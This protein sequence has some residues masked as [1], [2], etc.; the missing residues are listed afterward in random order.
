MAMRND[1][2]D[3]RPIRRLLQRLIQAPSA[4]ALVW[5]MVLLIGSFLAYSRW[6]KDHFNTIHARLEPDAVTLSEPHQ[7]VRT[8]LSSEVYDATRLRDLSPIDHNATA[9][10]ASAF[11]S[12][13]WVRHVQSVRKL[14]GGK[15]DVQLEYREPVAVFHV[16]S[17]KFD[18]ENGM[19]FSLDHEGYLLPNEKLTFDDASSFIQIEV[20]EAYPTGDEGNPFG[21]RRV[22]SA[23]LLAGLLSRVRDQVQVAKIMVSGDPRMNLVPQLELELGDG[24]RL[25]WGSPPG[26]EQPD[27]RN[28]KSKLSDLLSG[29]FVSGGNLRIAT[30]RPIQ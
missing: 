21:D 24:T 25:S 18:V 13:P 10:L 29:Q 17:D 26:M 7:Y 14:P 20:R 9:K 5:P 2:N 12:H 22:E 11:G 8:D 30:R 19:Y 1:K 4:L 6:Y 3:H 15:F 27:E 28:A 16:T 23:A